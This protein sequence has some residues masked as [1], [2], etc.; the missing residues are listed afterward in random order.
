LLHLGDREQSFAFCRG[1]KVSDAF[2][3]VSVATA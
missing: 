2:D 3:D 1:R